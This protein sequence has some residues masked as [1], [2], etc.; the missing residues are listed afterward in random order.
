MF[1]YQKLNYVL[2][3]AHSLELHPRGCLDRD[4]LLSPR[5]F[6]ESLPNGR[7]PGQGGFVRGKIHHWSAVKKPNWSGVN[8]SLVEVTSM[9]AYILPGFFR[10]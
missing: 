5:L 2:V 4:L 1:K 10:V 7:Q 9:T 3:F 6:D 8:K